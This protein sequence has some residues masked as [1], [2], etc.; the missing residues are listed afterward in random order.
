LKVLFVGEGNHDIGPSGEAW[1]QPRPAR[2]V[3]PVLARRVCPSIDA[4]SVA[5]PWREL[6]RL[7]PNARKGLE[8][9][10][11]AAITISARRF[12]CEGTVCVSDRDRGLDRLEALNRGKRRGL[13]VL[14]APH[15]A[16]VGVAVESVEAWTLGAPQ[17]IAE[18]LGISADRVRAALPAKHVEA[19]SESSGNEDHRPKAL[20]D[21]IASLAR[22]RDGTAFRCAVAERTEVEA[23]RAACPEGFGPFA[24]ELRAAFG[25]PH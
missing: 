11:A 9:K 4:A 8:A 3:V 6:S 21:R 25:P 12:G 24:D 5:L 13:E 23:L 15:T 17:A 19:L 20:I 1:G 18:E 22:Q 2:G 10:V 16:A 14:G 7:S